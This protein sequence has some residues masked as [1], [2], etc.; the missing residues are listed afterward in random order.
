MTVM[1]SHTAFISLLSIALGLS[2]LV[3]GCANTA[4]QPSTTV[5]PLA[6]EAIAPES[7]SGSE[8]LSTSQSEEL[9]DFPHQRIELVDEVEPG[10]DFDQFRAQ[11]QQAIRDRDAD[12]VRSLI[13]A[14][15]ISIGFGRPMTAED[16]QLEDPDSFFWN[17]LQKA[18]LPGCAVLENAGEEATVDP[19]TQVWECANVAQAFFE[20]YPPPADA[21]G[22]DDAIRSVIVVGAAVNVRLTPGSDR[23]IIAQLSNEVVEFDQETWESLPPEVREDMLTNLMDG[24]TPVILPDDRHGYVAN[25][26]AYR[27]LEP[28]F[29]F[30]KANGSWQILRVPAGD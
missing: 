8:T 5:S 25:L 15:G 22:V 17:S 20:Q 24:W 2:W 13:P 3:T 10:S 28:R 16:L 30:G 6:D 27:P 19:N 29:I 21:D 23:P 4:P 7:T 9:T 11:L 12:F 14:E 1:A 26:Y 18:M